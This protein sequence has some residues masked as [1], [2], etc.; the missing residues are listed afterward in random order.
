M[1]DI[2]SGSDTVTEARNEKLAT[3]SYG[4]TMIVTG[5]LVM[6]GRSGGKP[7]DRRYRSPTPGS[8]ARQWQII[9][10]QDYLVPRVADDRDANGTACGC[11]RVACSACAAR[12]DRR[13]DTD[14]AGREGHRR[15]HRRRGT[16]IGAPRTPPP[17]N[18]RC[19][20]ATTPSSR[21]SELAQINAGQR[22]EHPR[23]DGRSRPGVLRGHEAQPLVVNNTM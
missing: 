19:P 4:N 11:M 2:V 1:R 6:R 15:C 9:A 23:V 8:S 10:A 18:G 14:S 3:Q 21:F 17:A 20:P 7:F 12:A 22:G 16:R 5:W 13:R